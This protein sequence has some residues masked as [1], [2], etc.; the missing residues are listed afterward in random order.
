MQIQSMAYLQC[1]IGSSASTV[2]AVTSAVDNAG[3]RPPQ[4]E[5]LENLQLAATALQ[6][7]ILPVL[8]FVSGKT[9]AE[10]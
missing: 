4:E 6:E 3:G 10:L 7:A 5:F 9:A 8:K 1:V 2:C